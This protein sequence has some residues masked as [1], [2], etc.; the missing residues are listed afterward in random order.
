[1]FDALCAQWT[2]WCLKAYCQAQLFPSKRL[3]LYPNPAMSPYASL[4][5]PVQDCIHVDSE[6]QHQS[7]C[8]SAEESLSTRFCPGRFSLGRLILSLGL[9]RRK[10]QCLKPAFDHTTTFRGRSL[11]RSISRQCSLIHCICY[12]FLIG[13]REE[14]TKGEHGVQRR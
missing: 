13:L 2:V 14:V 6:V 7:C 12:V 8:R 11:D 1:M 4:I 9:S 3:L 5:R 10:L